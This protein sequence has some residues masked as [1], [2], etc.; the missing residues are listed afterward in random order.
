MTAVESFIVS[1]TEVANKF[2]KVADCKKKSL[3]PGRFPEWR[4]L[5]SELIS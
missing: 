4:A 3:A 1:A 2:G 5:G